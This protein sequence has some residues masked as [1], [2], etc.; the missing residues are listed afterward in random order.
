MIEKGLSISKPQFFYL[1]KKSLLALGTDA[2]VEKGH[3]KFYLY[4]V[5]K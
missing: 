2:D 3:M 4:M 5:P 1:L